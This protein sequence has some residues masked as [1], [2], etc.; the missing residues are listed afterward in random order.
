MNAVHESHPEDADRVLDTNIKGLVNVSRAVVPRMK[1]RG[2]GQVIH[3]SIYAIEALVL[4][5]GL[6]HQNQGP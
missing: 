4:G 3:G 2:Q 1:M 5:I 6:I